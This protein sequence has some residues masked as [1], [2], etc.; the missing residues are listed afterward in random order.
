MATQ[1]YLSLGNSGRTAVDNSLTYPEAN[2]S[3]PGPAKRPRENDD[4]GEGSRKWPK[5]L[6]LG[7]SPRPGN[8]LESADA[9]GI[10]GELSAAQFDSMVE[11]PKRELRPGAV[12]PPRQQLLHECH[13]LERR[14]QG[15]QAELHSHEDSQQ[16]VEERISKNEEAWS[17]ASQSNKD[18]VTLLRTFHERLSSFPDMGISGFLHSSDARPL[19]LVVTAADD[20]VSLHKM[21]V[22]RS[23]E[24]LTT[25]K[26]Q[27]ERMRN[28]M[29]RR[30]LAEA[31]EVRKCR[32]QLH[33]VEA[34]ILEVRRQLDVHERRSYCRR[35]F[36]GSR[37]L[38]GHKFWH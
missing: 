10:G 20:A 8:V 1:T 14:K 17:S 26:R 22:A 21:Q 33:K 2:V 4:H 7:S 13:E 28:D 32:E 38:A 15:L 29:R 25:R 18:L 6:G 37:Y 36:G 31:H 12:I 16:T 9:P 34:E 24:V 11:N 35:C 5:S 27:A 23:F 30:A 19:S 3:N